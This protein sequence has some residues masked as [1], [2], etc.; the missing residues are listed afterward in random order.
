MNSLLFWYKSCVRGERVVF[1]SIVTYSSFKLGGNSL[2][3][4]F[5][6][7][8]EITDFPVLVLRIFRCWFSGFSVAGL[9]DFPN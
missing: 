3:G 4:S 6:F 1:P 2:V 5:R 7:P 9:V 8:N